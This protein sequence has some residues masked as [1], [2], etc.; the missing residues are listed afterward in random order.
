[1]SPSASLRI[2]PLATLLLLTARQF[3]LK[4]GCFFDKCGDG[5]CQFTESCG[6]GSSANSC[7]ADCG[8]CP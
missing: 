8:T 2:I 4:E 3:S 5:I 7:K 1:M 6:N